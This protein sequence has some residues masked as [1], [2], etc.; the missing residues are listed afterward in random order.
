MRELDFF[1]EACGEFDGFRLDG[2]RIVVVFK[3]SCPI[4]L[5]RSAEKVLRSLKPGQRVAII[6]I[7]GDRVKVRLE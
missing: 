6:R 3:D 2:E 5:P 1:E 7:N 4:V